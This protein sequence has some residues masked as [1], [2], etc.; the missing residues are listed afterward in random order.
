[1]VLEGIVKYLM[2]TIILFISLFVGWFSSVKYLEPLILKMFNPASHEK[3]LDIWFSMFA[4]IELVIFFVYMVYV[5]KVH[6]LNKHL[7]KSSSGR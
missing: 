4:L 2:A 1:M 7:T 6:K 3:Y 5:Y